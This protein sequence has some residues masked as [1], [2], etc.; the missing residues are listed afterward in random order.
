VVVGPLSPAGHAGAPA[1]RP[2]VYDLLTGHPD[3]AS[4]GEHG[5]LEPNVVRLFA[6]GV[7]TAETP[8]EAAVRRS[9][10]GENDSPARQLARYVKEVAENRAT[11]MEVRL[12][13]RRD[14]YL[15]GG[16]QIPSLE[17]RYA[18]VRFT[19]PN[20]DYRHQH[21]NVRIENG[22]QFGDLPQFVDFDYVARVAR[23]NA[24]SLASLARA[25]V[26]P[27]DAKILTQRLTNDTELTWSA[28][29]EPDLAGYEVVWRET[30]EPLWTNVRW[31]GN[32]T[33]TTMEAMSKDNF[34]FGI[35]AVDRD[36]HRSPVSF[37]L[38]QR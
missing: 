6:E 33:S 35:R 37:P 32:V 26:G 13:W 10:G 21:Q 7:P 11:K 29:P 24:V 15:R 8:E 18:A 38:P 27:K 23:V 2:G 30:T 16:D 3:G 17:R 5:E 19:E 31:V 20:E 14:R 22:V 12:V 36:G 4:V 34:F 28:N 1:G 9:V 25:P